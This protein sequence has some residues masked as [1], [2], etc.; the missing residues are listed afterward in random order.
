MRSDTSKSVYLRLCSALAL[1][2]GSFTANAQLE[3]HYEGTDAPIVVNAEPST[4]LEAIY[5]VA[6]TQGL[7]LQW[8]D[9]SARWSTY[10]NLGGGFAQEITDVTRTGTSSTIDALPGDM[11]YIVESQG[12][13]HCFWV[14]N[15]NQHSLNLTSL[16]ESDLSDCDRTYLIASG[17]GNPMV[18]YT[19][20]GQSRT[21]SRQL[22][23][24]YNTLS[25]DDDS[26]SFI[27]QTVNETFAD[28]AQPL[29]V[30]AILAPTA[31]TLS[32]DRFLEQWQRQQAVQS[33]EI[34]PIA[35]DAHT[36]AEQ[37]ENDHD[38]LQHGSSE[39]QL[40]GSAPATVTFTAVPTPA[41]IFTEWQFSKTE[42][43]DD[44]TDRFSTPQFDYTFTEAGTTYVRFM[45][46]NAQ[47]TCYYYGDTYTVS[48]GESAI[49]CP[50]AFSPGNQDGVNDIWK[51]SY[52]SITKFK[53]S[54]FNR[55]GK[56]LA[57]F[58][59]PWQGWDGKVGGKVVPSGVYFYVIDAQ[60]ADGKHYKLS[61][62]IN[63]IN[64]RKN[65]T[66]TTPE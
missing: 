40:G 36:T 61:G 24:S 19:I 17:S 64:V 47:G 16:T 27:Q 15:Y 30:P 43:F 56:Q 18:Y 46:A 50:N 32:G 10:S 31:F 6:N 2:L 3:L 1:L 9:A 49:T 63:V 51:V 62:D 22:T 37:D 33:P 26:E 55:W 20:N 58:N 28:I 65:P 5:V 48:V 60:G 34:E 54:I 41:A 8:P 25:W 35:V 52:R 23:L 29:G 53:C 11:G 21:L 44:V 12:R 39:A 38:N 14:F 42:D 59:Q 4:G 13:Q 7:K 66:P 45:C 57:Q